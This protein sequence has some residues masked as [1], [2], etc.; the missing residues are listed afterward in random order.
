M[1]VNGTLG[2]VQPPAASNG[3]EHRSRTHDQEL[4]GKVY[5]RANLTCTDKLE[6]PYYSY[7]AYDP[8]CIHCGMEDDL[9]S[10]EQANVVH[11]YI[12]LAQLAFLA[13]P[14]LFRRKRNLITSSSAPGIKKK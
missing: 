6:V 8:I 13:S 4:I 5:V 11:M 2:V 9:I 3:H 1:W 12:L 7:C 10:G 14:K